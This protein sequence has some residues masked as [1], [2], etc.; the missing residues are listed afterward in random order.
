MIHDLVIHLPA[1]ERGTILDA[2]AIAENREDTTAALRLCQSL[3][4]WL[5]SELTNAAP[6]VRERALNKTII[7]AQQ[8]IK[9]KS[10]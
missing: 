7:T 8:I 3:L 10:V 1:T 9:G 6:L 2:W 4:L 5:R